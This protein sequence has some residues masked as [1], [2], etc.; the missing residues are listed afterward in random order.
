MTNPHRYFVEERKNGDIA[1]KGQGN[2]KASRVLDEGKESKAKILA[3][4]FAGRHGVVEFKG[5]DGKFE[6]PCPSCSRNRQ[7]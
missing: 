1:V 5:P 3:H 7:S 2:E 4:H 6:C